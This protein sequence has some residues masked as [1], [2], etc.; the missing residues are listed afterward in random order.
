M[1]PVL[2]IPLLVLP[3][4]TGCS[5]AGRTSIAMLDGRPR[6]ST[7]FF[8][9]YGSRDKSASLEVYQQG[10][11]PTRPYKEIA[12]FT[13]DGDG[14]QEADAV[15]GFIILGRKCGANALVVDRAATL[16]KEGGGK[17]VDTQTKDGIEGG[18]AET[19]F[20]PNAR[21]VYRATAVVWAEH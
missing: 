16:K 17:I 21:C 13:V 8:W 14:K 4:L 19:V 12:L 20:Y 5:F 3:F 10:K 18:G 15:Q 6:P 2:I 9:T 11:K 7:G 1:K